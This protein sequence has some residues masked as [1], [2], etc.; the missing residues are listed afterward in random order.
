MAEELFE[1]MFTKKK[2]PKKDKNEL[3]NKLYKRP[4]R[5]K[6]HDVPHFQNTTPNAIHQADLIMMPNDEGYRYILVVVDVATRKTDAE[7]LKSRD[8]KSV[9]DAF[10]KI[11]ARKTLSVPLGLEVDAGTEFEGNV[12]HWFREKKIPI[13]VAQPGRSR[14]QAIVERR[15]QFIVQGLNKRM[16]A[17]EL[18]TGKT[19]R[20]WVDDLP[21]LIRVLNKNRPHIVQNDDNHFE[22][23]PL[24]EL[25]TKVRVMLD[26]PVDPITGKKL[27]GKFVLRISVGTP[28]SE[29]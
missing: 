17:Q 24:L 20:E 8:S 18:L 19:S 29:Q 6:G 13:R 12:A 4:V 26:K 1:E 16:S 22:G 25:G 14:Q 15:N 7:A 5:D 28:R 27:H 3:L 9:L 21:V 10:K 23:K 11:Y 2:R